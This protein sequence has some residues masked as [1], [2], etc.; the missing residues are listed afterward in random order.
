MA[1][2]RLKPWWFL[3]VLV[4]FI[5]CGETAPTTPVVKVPAAPVV[6][7]PAAP[8]VETLTDEEVAEIKKLPVEDQK[9]ALEQKICPV[10]GG[11]LGDPGMGAPVK[12]SAKGTTF[13]I[14]CDG[15][16]PK[17]EKQP[18]VVLAKLAELKSKK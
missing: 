17:V 10:G 2:T 13:F 3:P 4:A 6:A 8:A 9:L 18:D 5:G 1:S 12:V 14:C 15:C 11:H 16:K 7:A